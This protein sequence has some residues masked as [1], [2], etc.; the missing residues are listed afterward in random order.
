MAADLIVI[1]PSRGRPQNLLRLLS[2]WESTR[3]MSS[4]KAEL[5]AIIDHDDPCRRDYESLLSD[6]RPYF[7]IYIPAPPRTPIGP[8][9]NE[10]ARKLKWDAQR[11]GFM[12]DDHMPRTDCWDGAIVDALDLLGSGIVYGNDLLQGEKLPTAAFM[13][14]DIV[15]QLGGMC[16][17]TLEHLYID[18]Y[19]LELGRAM[20]RLRYLPEVVIEHLHPAAGKAQQD[21]TYAEANA[22]DRD[23]RDRAAFEVWRRDGLAADVA[24]LRAA[25]VC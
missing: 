25:G 22:P 3:R 5:W 13:T 4:V 23:R 20:G 19:W 10:L 15:R 1:V 21:Q 7:D 2:A 24:K 16:P 9:L 14:S 12:G 6:T 17:P 8:L 18:N 11:I